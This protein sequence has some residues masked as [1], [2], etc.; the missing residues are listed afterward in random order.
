MLSGHLRSAT[1]LMANNSTCTLGRGLRGP[2]LQSGDEA[3]VVQ[4]TKIVI[5][6]QKRYRPSGSVHDPCAECVCPDWAN[7]VVPLARVMNAVAV[8]S[9]ARMDRGCM[10]LFQADDDRIMARLRKTVRK[11]LGLLYFG[12]RM[13][14]DPASMVYGN[15]GGPQEL[16]A[17]SEVY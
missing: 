16:D 1:P 12:L 4:G 8:V 3:T 13:S 17:M 5:N 9:P 6:R 10:G 15:I 7:S 14:A 11:N 2:C